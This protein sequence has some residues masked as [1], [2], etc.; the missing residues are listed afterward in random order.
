MLGIVI[1]VVIKKFVMGRKERERERRK[2]EETIV[3]LT[4]RNTIRQSDRHHMIAGLGQG[5]GLGRC[6]RVTTGRS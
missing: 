3:I 6:S 5:G 1:I 4:H 2:K